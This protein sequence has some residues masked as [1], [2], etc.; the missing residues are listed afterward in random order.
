MQ[1]HCRQAEQD[2]GSAAERGAGG[3]HLLH[4]WAWNMERR[5][6]QI[7][8]VWRELTPSAKHEPVIQ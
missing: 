4:A 1:R 8:A 6:A 2:D 7:I 3:R 5:S